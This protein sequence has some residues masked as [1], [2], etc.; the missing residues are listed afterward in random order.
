MP[1]AQLW[2]I[3]TNINLNPEVLLVPLQALDCTWLVCTLYIVQYNI[4]LLGGENV[5]FL[6]K[7][8]LKVLSGE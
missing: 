2:W 7:K 5:F 3:V 1:I 6:I 4:L 8:F